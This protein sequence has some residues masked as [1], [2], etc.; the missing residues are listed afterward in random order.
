[1]NVFLNTTMLEVLLRMLDGLSDHV[2]SS[3]ASI[4]R[5]KSFR[6]GQAPSNPQ[7]CDNAVTLIFNSVATRWVES[8][9]Q[10]ARR[11]LSAILSAISFYL[12]THP[13]FP[14]T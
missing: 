12:R 14:V 3:T 8:R 7:G 13:A 9:L 10:D 6:H 1:L 5:R 4:H 2:V 11:R